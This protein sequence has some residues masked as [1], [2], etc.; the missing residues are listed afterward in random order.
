MVFLATLISAARCG[1][2]ALCL[3][4]MFGMQ[5]EAQAVPGSITVITQANAQAGDDP[6]VLEGASPASTR[7]PDAWSAS[8]SRPSGSV[9]YRAAFKLPSS[10]GAGDALSLYIERVCSRVEVYLNGRSVQGH[11]HRQAPATRNCDHP[12]LFAL[13][14]A[15][16]DDSGNVL[17]LRVQG[18][19]LERVAAVQR[20]AG[21]SQLKVGP[22]S[23]LAAE[24]E[25]KLFWRIT[26]VQA[27]AGV[28]A[29]LGWVMLV[30]GWPKRRNG[31]VRILGWLLIGWALHSA[32]LW[33]HEL[34]LEASMIELASSFGQ[35][36]L[37]SLAV[38][39]LLRAARWNPRWLEATV[40]AHSVL[41]PIS[42]LLGG[43]LQVH[44]LSTVWT[45]LLGLEVLAAM[46]FYLLRAWPRQR[47]DVWCMLPVLLGVCT[48]LLFEL[49][50]QCRLIEAPSV[51]VVQ[52]GVSLALIAVSAR[53]LI[54]F[55][56]AAAAGV[57]SPPR[58]HPRADSADKKG[59]ELQ[60]RDLSAQH[61]Q[62]LAELAALGG[63]QE[64]K[65]LASGVPASPAETERSLAQMAELRVEQVTAQ[66]RK[67]IA[68]DLH[69]DL[70]AK[71]LTIV[72]TSESD[73]ISTLAREALEE[74]RLSVRG[75]SGKP[76][77]LADAL[78]DW[79]AETVARLSQASIEADWR[80]PTEEA[81]QRL[82]AR[83]FVQTTRILREAISNVI[84]HSG[85]SQCKVRC[86][87]RDGE[88]G[89]VVQDNGNGIST[90]LDGNLDRGHGMASMKNRAKQ[91]QGQCLVESGPGYGTVIRLT[92]PL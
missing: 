85:A 4:L 47:M 19:A 8:R 21:L 53:A 12:R 50:V 52:L 26:A 43:P 71:L 29:V 24:L 77:R 79:R 68:A 34:P 27:L 41:V 64:H 37:A 72:H 31:H 63:G 11:E 23:L 81:E 7:L 49:M 32:W 59:L 30:L 58:R 6:A 54:Q 91:M 80:G 86:G 84:K 75:L 76:M 44:L 1:A 62:V 56:T 15:L 25:S 28:C 51:D 69:D 61:E 67:R 38:V 22:Q 45:G 16:L 60:L 35:A 83:S 88:F 9:W 20:A 14:T 42:M 40:L 65:R 18:L 46:V 70:G 2:L 13:P 39:F 74:M 82:P 92:L 10:P 33:R 73:H 78:A 90:E 89:L 57:A 66:E 5:A 48:L 87:I 36:L 17:D 55:S 3:G